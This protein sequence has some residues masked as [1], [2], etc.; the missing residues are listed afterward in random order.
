LFLEDIGEEPYR[1]DRMLTQLKLAGILNQVNGIVFGQFPEC[2]PKSSGPSL[3]LSEVIAEVTAD[4]PIPILVDFPYGHI[5][6]KY[7]LP[8][9]IEAVLEAEAGV[10]EIVEPAVLG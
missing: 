8:I 9:G 5:D 6:E 4:L 2:V 7:T 3:N 1:I 10:L